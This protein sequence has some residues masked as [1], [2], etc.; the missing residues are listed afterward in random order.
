MD[1]V[2]KK[3]E[4]ITA[5][6]INIED[7]ESYIKPE[8]LEE[9]KSSE[10]WQGMPNTQYGV[11]IPTPLS[12]NYSYYPYIYA[13]EYKSVIGNENN[14]ED[15]LKRSEQDE[16]IEP[17]QEGATN[18]YLNA[19]S[20]QPYQTFWRFLGDETRKTAYKEISN[21]S[22]VSNYYDLLYETNGNLA[23]YVASRCVDNSGVGYAQFIIFVAYKNYYG[24]YMSTQFY[25]MNQNSGGAEIKLFPIVTVNLDRVTGSEENGFYINID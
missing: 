14:S 20:I 2:K 9:I 10:V 3:K 11:K 6:S 15:S 24:P 1:L 21:N 16:F 13:K 25:S 23:Y 7:I 19:S 5:R 18:G 22:N 4:G 17:N 8:I 12:Q